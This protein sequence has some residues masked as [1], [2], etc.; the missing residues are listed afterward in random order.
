MKVSIVTVTWNSAKTIARAMD[1]VLHQTYTDIEYVVVDGGSTDGTIDIIQSYEPKFKGRLYWISEKDEG[2]YDAMNKGI[3]MATGDVVGI[4]NSDDFFTSY[5]VMERMVAEF[6]DDVEAVYGD[7]HYV[8]ESDLQKNIRSYSGR[9][10]HPWMVRIGFIPP[11][12]SFYVRRN[13]YLKYGLYDKSFRI[14]A[15]VEM[16]ARLTYVNKIR[17]KY[18]NMDF[19]TM[20]VGGESTKSIHNRWLGTKEDLTACRKLGIKSNILFVHFK[21]FLKFFGYL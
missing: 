20:L 15:D 2:I 12:P 9:L 11:H 10:F 16:I 8:R 14:S 6:T 5:Y 1:S 7:V 17:T 13:T 19:V 18:I 21:Y 3:K 4:L